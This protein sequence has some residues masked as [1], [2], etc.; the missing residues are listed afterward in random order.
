MNFKEYFENEVL[1][2][3]F[4]EALIED[5]V[6]GTIGNIASAPF[7]FAGGA[8]TN[9]GS[10]IG[11]GAYSATKGALRGAKGLGKLGLGGLQGIT[12]SPLVGVQTAASGV[13]DILSGV[14]DVAG[15]AVQAAASP[16][17]AL[18]RGV[19]ATGEPILGIDDFDPK[20]N[21]V[22]KFFGMNTWK[23]PDQKQSTSNN[24][25]E[26]DKLLADITRTSEKVDR[27]RIR[28]RLKTLDPNRYA[29]LVR[30]G[31]AKVAARKTASQRT[32]SA[33]PP[34]LPA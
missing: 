33:T 26:F 25:K 30:R 13:G 17:S 4:I 10:Q 1:E 32:G 12:G 2:D 14:R 8:A 28:Q 20:R 3:Y 34:P 22:Q 31:R 27:D 19:Q 24:S 29:E 9:L 23:K 5:G 7:K 6:L 21:A 16:I 18:A 15:G 11:R